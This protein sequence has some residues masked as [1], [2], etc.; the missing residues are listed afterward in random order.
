MAFLPE[1]KATTNRIWIK[2]NDYAHLTDIFEIDQYKVKDLERTVIFAF[3][4]MVDTN[5]FIAHV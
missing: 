3:S 5:L 1:V 2:S 4:I